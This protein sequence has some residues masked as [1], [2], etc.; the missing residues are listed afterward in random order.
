MPARLPIGDQAL[1]L[2][3]HARAAT[4]F[5]S[6]DGESCASIPANLDSRQVLPLRSAAF[7]DWVTANFY[8]E[9]ETAPSPAAYQSTVRTL[10]ARARYG[11][12]RSRKVDIRIGLEG[13]PFLPSKIMLD[14]ANAS[15]DL[16]E[17]TSQGWRITDNL[18]HP[19]RQSA[20]TLPLP[21]PIESTTASHESFDAFTELFGLGESVR[22]RTLAWIAAAVRP[23]GPYPMLVIRGPAG[24][25]KSL[26]ARALR[27]IVDPSA[28]PLR[29]LPPSDR[30]VLQLAFQSWM[31]A[32]DPVHRVSSK[33]ADALSAIS[34]GDT[35]E[36]AQP[37]SRQPR[38]FQVSRPILLVAPSDENERT[39]A[40]PRSF[41]NRTLAINLEP[42]AAQRAE[43]ALWSEF[44]ALRPVLVA[45]L[46]DTVSTALRRIRDI[47][48]KNV[49][50]FPDGAAW[51]AAA[52][53]ALGL[54]ES[55]AANALTDPDAI[56]I[57]ANP[58]RDAIYAL[59][60]R[61]SSWIGDPADLLRQLRA[62]APLAALPANPRALVQA[63][64]GIAGIELRASKGARR[65]S[66]FTVA[67]AVDAPKYV[68]RV[69]L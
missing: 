10:E 19:F 8:A 63:L 30:E 9:Y 55:I 31:L 38:V 41:S 51:V 40:P 53:P 3:Y 32:F 13:D 2:L 48:L 67:R 18:S 36:M 29:R 5:R 43:A 27:A 65:E 46:A 49:A 20:A 60:G 39:W 4:P 21:L 35:L 54:T 25:G 37:D 62:M 15:G 26:L 69:R 45:A 64:S 52:A 24:S 12:F 44:E 6:E 7:R 16:V 57:G 1:A 33:I 47:D 22:P 28:A 14:L 61:G 34:S 59:L 17:I 42:I 68:A 56:W 50:R 23:T 58:L 66:I 11:E